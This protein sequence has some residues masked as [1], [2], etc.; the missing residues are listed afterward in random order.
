MEYSSVF[1]FDY[2][3]GPNAS[4]DPRTRSSLEEQGIMNRALK[5]GILEG[6]D[7]GLEVVP[8]TIKVM[9]AAAAKT[10]LAIEWFPI[11][12]GKTA[13]DK[14]GYTLPP[15]TLEKLFTLDGWVLG[16]IGHQA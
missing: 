14:L 3:T 4:A 15:G 9:K 7:I 10:G 8:E 11:P 5:I 1:S 6:D 12:I 2:Y 13:F 16:P